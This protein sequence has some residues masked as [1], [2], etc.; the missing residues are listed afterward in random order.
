MS[1]KDCFHA[2]RRGEPEHG[3]T[4][5]SQTGGKQPRRSRCSIQT[6][7]VTQAACV[8]RRRPLN[9]PG[10]VETTESIIGA[11]VLK[12]RAAA[13]AGIQHP[14]NEAALAHY[15]SPRAA[16]RSFPASSTS[17]LSSSAPFQKHTSSILL[18]DRIRGNAQPL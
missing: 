16:A 7:T 1:G 4:G 12:R 8:C 13:A 17:L 15:S 2:W 14:Q 6:K 18:S 3:F 5:N 9:L 10:C 11:N